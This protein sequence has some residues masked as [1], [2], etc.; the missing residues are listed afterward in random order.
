MSPTEECRIA[1]VTGASRGI[2]RGCAL[3]LGGAGLEVVL[4]ARKLDELEA[5][6]TEIR[7][8]GGR[9]RV[10]QCD[11]TRTTEVH[12]LF[13]ELERCDIL[14]NNA[15]ANR[16]QP[17]IDVDVETLDALLALNV[18]SMFVTAQAAAKIMTRARSGVIINMSSQMGHVGASN[19]TVYCMCKHAVE[20]LTKAMAVEL[21]PLGI[22]VNAVAPTYIDTPMTRP[23]FENEIFRADVLRRIPLARIGTIDEVV[24]AIMF[25]TSPAASLINGTS[26][27]VDG[28]YTAQ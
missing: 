23:Y 20:G 24:A 22:R 26:L 28:G 6:A 12:R 18:Q 11:V 5:V 16:P 9:A 19:R 8:R 10:A 4:V 27:L 15:G 13:D 7:D 21:G 3:A 2:G 1:V 17:F 25:L 14:I